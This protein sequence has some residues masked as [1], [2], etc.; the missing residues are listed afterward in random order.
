MIAIRK[1]ARGKGHVEVQEVPEPKPR[2]NEVVIGVDSAGICGTD[3]HIYL[4]EFPTEP[5]VTLGHEF[6]GVVT[7]VGSDVREWSLGDRVTSST[8]FSTCG[9]CDYC[10][11]GRPNLCL[12]RRSI[13]SRRDGAFA[14]RVV[15]P[16]A[17]LFRLPDSL[18]FESAAMTEPLACTIHGVLDRSKVEPADNVVISGPGPIGLL[19]LQLVRAAGARAIV[20]G[21]SAD[22]ARLSIA[23]GLGADAT[24]NVDTT[25]DLLALV[26]DLFG[27]YGA[28]VGIE[29]SGAAPAA[30]TILSLLRR[31]A[32]FCQMGLYG[33]PIPFDQ[34]QVCYK[35]LTVTGTNASS[36][37][38][39]PRALKLL[40]DRRINVNAMISHRYPLTAWPDALSVAE[41]KQGLKILLKPA[42]RH[43]K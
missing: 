14:E 5:P 23:A 16:A 4:D 24:I 25:D 20:L 42:E 26:E 15:V 38:S 2:A 39:W 43:G 7:E 10:R 19:A 9:K 40:T 32:R 34:D 3:L 30:Q 33:K 17:N 21:T 28:D 37:A 6:A 22:S 12:D 27:I 41:S 31:G 1:L 18:D 13:G 11:C 8:Y 29:C 36:V 35:E